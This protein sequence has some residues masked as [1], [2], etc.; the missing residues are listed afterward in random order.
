MVQTTKSKRFAFLLVKKTN[1]PEEIDIVNRIVVVV[2]GILI[3]SMGIYCVV[4][5]F[6]LFTL[7][8]IKHFDVFGPGRYTILLGVILITLCA[9]YVLR[10]FPRRSIQSKKSDWEMTGKVAIIVGDMALYIYLIP[11]LGFLLASLV[12]LII[13]NRVVGFKPWLLNI[14]ISI[15][16][17]IAYHVLFVTILGVPFPR[18]ML[19]Q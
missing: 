15:G 18:G 6:N 8:T 14:S 10:N 16:M 4:E 13:I 17:S 1:S 12:F 19:F 7:G 2:E 9:I 11:L 3:L 5:G